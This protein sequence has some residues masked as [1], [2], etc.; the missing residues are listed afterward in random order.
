MSA[1]HTITPQNDTLHGH[2]SRDLAPI[3][4]IQSGDTVRYQTLDADWIGTWHGTLDNPPATRK[5]LGGSFRPRVSPQDDGHALCG[6]IAVEGAKP[7][8]M[9]AIHINRIVPGQWGWTQPWTSVPPEQKDDLPVI[10]W[11][12]DAETMIGRNHLGHTVTL[13]PFMGV[14]GMPPAEAGIHRTTM[15]RATG[16]NIDCKELVAGST[17]YLPIAVEG[18][19]FSLG[20]GHAAQGDGESGGTAIE[21]PMSLVDVTFELV[22]NPL[23]PT[24]YAK[25]PQGWLTFGFD[26]DL[27]TAYD[28]AQAAMQTLVAARYDVEPKIALALMGSVV[29]MRITQTVNIVRGVHAVLPHGALR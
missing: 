3:L 14:M 16:G 7:G 26:E 25:T 11:A 13:R 27:Q 20:D 21:C 8:M 2:F 28:D 10:L 23:L 12:L 22:E 5:A 29:D 9:L 1:T 15:P 4:T 6:P 24:A 17:L 18:G 19:L